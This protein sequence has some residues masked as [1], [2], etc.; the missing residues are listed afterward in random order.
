MWCPAPARSVMSCRGLGRCQL[1][2]RPLV[3]H[4][5]NEAEAIGLDNTEIWTNI[6]CLIKYR[7][8][9][10]MHKADDDMAV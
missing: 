5:C 2:V 1:W 10:N 9:K 8:S 6:C 7:Q 3:Q 4:E